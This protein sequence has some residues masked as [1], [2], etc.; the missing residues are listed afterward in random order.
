MDATLGRRPAAEAVGTALLIVFGAGS[1][2]AALYLADGEL[3]DAGH[4]T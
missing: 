4:R 1:V 2:L 3:D